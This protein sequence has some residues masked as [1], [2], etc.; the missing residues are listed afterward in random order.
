MLLSKVNLTKCDFVFFR[1][2]EEADENFNSTRLFVRYYGDTKRD[3]A[4]KYKHGT[5]LAKKLHE[6]ENERKHLFMIALPDG[7]NI[8]L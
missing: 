7:S 6:Q 3:I 8:V 2:K 4:I 5:A 1:E